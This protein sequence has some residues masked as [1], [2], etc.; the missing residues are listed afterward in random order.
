MTKALILA[1]AGVV[2]LA[3]C[4]SADTTPVDAA[5]ATYT[6]D[7][8]SVTL[9]NGSFEQ[10]VAPGSAS[11]IL[12][13][14]TDKRAN[15]DINGDG[16]QDAAVVVTYSG[17]GSGT[18]SYLAVLIGSG[19]GKGSAT[20]AVLLGDRITVDAVR[21]D[22]G[23]V[24]VDMLDRKAGEPMATAPSVKVTR[25]FQLQGAQLSELK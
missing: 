3:A 17:G 18:F 15:A 10:A 23:K 4:Q 9:A 22:A 11:K 7:K 24:V 2:A 16:K 14:L 8:N 21:I 12:A 25:T 19:A 5:N 13:K 6:L 20:N 1:V